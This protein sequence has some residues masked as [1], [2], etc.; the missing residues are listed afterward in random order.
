[1]NQ[2][3]EMLQKLRDFRMEIMLEIQNEDS[4][5]NIDI[6]DVVYCGQL[7]FIESNEEVKKDVFL[8][9][10]NVDGTMKF[11]YYADKDL[12]AIDYNE[13]IIP[14]QEYQ[15]VDMKPLIKN[16]DKRISL[17]NLEIEKFSK[18]AETMGIE[19]NQIDACSEIDSKNLNEEELLKKAVNV[20]S[21]FNPGDK[22][23][24]TE[25]FGNLIQGANKYDKIA[26]IYSHNSNDRFKLVGITND[27][28][29]E[30]LENL[31]QTEGI[32]P[33]ERIVTSDRYGDN[34]TENTASAMF[35]I[36]GRPDEGF[37]VNIGSAGCIEVNYVRR[38]TDDEY[39]SIP[40]EAEH[41]RYVSSELKRGMDK[42]KNTRVEEEVDRAQAE[43]EN[44]NDKTNWK[45][46]DDNPN[47]DIDHENIIITEDGK[48]ISLEEEAAKAKV[49]VEEF[50]RIYKEQSESLSLEERIE[51]VHE[52]IEE[53]F[54]G[55]RQI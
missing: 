45:N 55:P 6:E 20:K 16:E 11:E 35:K 44:H 21:E 52:E 54:I 43:M 48:E 8:V 28:K 24:S 29:V 49:S 23:T 50:K 51:A 36:K 26:V 3:E 42:S 38:S 15:N 27:G 13:M 10:K 46:I 4:D 7:N 32:N 37:A 25:N 40:I 47:N 12:I 34:T 41:T 53:Q 2:N 33:T 39:L 17:N 22:I 19:E 14:T 18:M 5:K 31:I 30:E 1:M 9:V